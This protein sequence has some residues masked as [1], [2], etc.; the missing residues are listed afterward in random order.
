MGDKFEIKNYQK[1]NDIEMDIELDEYIIFPNDNIK[2][3]IHLKPKNKKVKFDLKNL[4]IILKLTQF[5]KYE[6]QYEGITGKTEESNL[7]INTTP[8]YEI[9]RNYDESI[10][11]ELQLA[12]KDNFY[13]SFEFRKKNYFIFVRHLFTIELPEL[14]IAQSKGIIICKYPEKIENII[15]EEKL[16]KIKYFTIFKDVQTKK[17][18]IAYEFQIKKLIFSLDEKIPIKLT[19]NKTDL[20]D[21]DIKSIEFT[22][23]KILKITD[24][25]SLKFWGEDSRVK[26]ITIFSKKYEDDE[27]KNKIMKYLENIEIDKNDLPE[28]VKKN[29]EPKVYAKEISRFIKFDDDFI[30]RDELRFELNPS[31]KTDL[32]FCEYKVILNIK[33]NKKLDEIKDEFLIDLY[34]LKPNVIDKNNEHYFKIE[35][36]SSFETQTGEQTD[37]DNLEEE[38]KNDDDFINM[39]KKDYR[40][41]LNDKNDINKKSKK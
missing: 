11:I 7:K 38:N 8:P 3:K 14:K 18:K 22:L 12:K 16:D 32:F 33:F 29:N 27:V 28:F 4:K 24:K 19:V 13:P 9:H 21:V 2:G 5:M 35:E 40:S 15:K 17:G 6:F 10:S 30:E 36:S 41:A 39:D 34:T 37:Y 1:E 20:K 23:E 31:I 25:I 26:K